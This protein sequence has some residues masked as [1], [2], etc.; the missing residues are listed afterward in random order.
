MQGLDEARR[1]IGALRASP[2]ENRS[3]VEALGVLSRR[4]TA[5]T[6]VRVRMEISDSGALPGEV[7]SELFRIASEALTN[8]R[9]HAAAREVSLRLETIR[10][11]FAPDRRGCR[12]RISPARRA[13][14]GFGLVG[15]EDRRAL[16]GGRAAIR[17]AP[18]RGTTVTVTIPVTSTP[19]RGRTTPEPRGRA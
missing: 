7:E 12:P 13:P 16:V 10:G 3:L 8:V 18:G 5:E 9:K 4:F 15:I 17:S 1:S 6:G 14:R 19:R 11:A 2:L